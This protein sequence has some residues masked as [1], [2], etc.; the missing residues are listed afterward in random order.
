MGQVEAASERNLGQRRSAAAAMTNGRVTQNHVDCARPGRKNHTGKLVC[1]QS[2]T[3]SSCS[4]LSISSTPSCRTSTTSA[5]SISSSSSDSHS[6]FQPALRRSSSNAVVS[7]VC[8]AG[9][10]GLGGTAS[11]VQLDNVNPS[12]REFSLCAQKCKVRF[13][14]AG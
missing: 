5:I 2:H 6:G 14:R 7:F 4:F 13:M 1:S 9:G 11:P 8:P 3:A 10:V 12:T